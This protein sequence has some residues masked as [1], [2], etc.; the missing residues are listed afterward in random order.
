MLI[1]GKRINNDY[2]LFLLKNL[3]ENTYNTY[4]TK[5]YI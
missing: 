5:I 2:Y 4:F 3:Y 1:A